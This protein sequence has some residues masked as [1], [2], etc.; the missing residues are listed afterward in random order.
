M[1]SQNFW[2]QKSLEAFSADEWESLCDGCAKCCVHKLQ[3]EDTD[4]V[5]YTNVACRLLDISTCRCTHYHNRK[6]IVPDCVC[7][8]PQNIRQYHWLPDTC[9]YKLIAEGKSLQQWHPLLSG[10]H[11]SVEQA[12]ISVTGKVVPEDQ[13]DDIQSHI[14]YPVVREQKLSNGV[15]EEKPDDSKG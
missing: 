15:Y 2:E 11:L 7:L 3:D 13:A 1:K 14:V 5:Y 8:T 4:E 12:G 10:T 6:E 9:A